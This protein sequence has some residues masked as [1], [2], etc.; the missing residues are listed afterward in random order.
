MSVKTGHFSHV[1]HMVFHIHTPSSES[2][3]SSDSGE[4]LRL[5]DSLSP[6]YTVKIIEDNFLRK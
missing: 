4:S 1:F 3:R 6:A 5:A 2:E